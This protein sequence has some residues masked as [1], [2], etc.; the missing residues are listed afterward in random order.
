MSHVVKI[1]VEREEIIKAVGH[2]T[3]FSIK[4]YLQLTEKHYH[5]TVIKDN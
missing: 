1:G 3:G 4:L 2:N 5:D